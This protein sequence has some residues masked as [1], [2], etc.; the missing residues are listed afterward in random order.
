MNIHLDDIK[1]NFIGLAARVEHM[2]TGITVT[3]SSSKDII[4][5]YTEAFLL[6]KARIE[7]N[8]NIVINSKSYKTTP[9][10]QLPYMNGA[11]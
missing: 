6:L 7:N 5:N 9:V 2:P 1:T 3:Q 4:R 10:I 8:S 11:K